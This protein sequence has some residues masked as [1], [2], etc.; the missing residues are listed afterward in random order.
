MKS[1]PITGVSSRESYSER[2]PRREN[3]AGAMAVEVLKL[4]REKQM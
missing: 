2:E 4:R 3:G 1:V